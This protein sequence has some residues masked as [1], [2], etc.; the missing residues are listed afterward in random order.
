MIKNY[1]RI[2]WRYILRNKVNS[3]INITGLAIGLVC[4]VLLYFYIQDELSYDR[5]LANA[6]YIY[7]VDLDANMSGEEFRTSNTPPSVGKALLNSF[8]EIESFTRIFHPHDIVVRSEVNG[9]ESFFTERKVLGVDSNFLEIFDYKILKGNAEAA[10]LQPNDIVITESIAK[11][12]FGTE[13]PM[14]KV[15]K[16][17][18]DRKPF[19][20]RAVLQDIPSQSTLDFDILRPI[21]SFPVVKRFTWSWVWLQVETYV[22]LRDHVARNEVSIR[23]LEAKFPDMVQKQ[24]ASAFERIGQPLD[25]L[26]KKGGKWDFK[27]KPL[28]AVHLF[29]AGIGGRHTTLGDIKYVQIFT[30][31]AVFIIIIACVNFV[32]LSTAQSGKRAR[33]VGIRKVLGSQ[34]NQLIRQF[35]IEALVY[36]MVAAFIALI[37]IVILLQPFN[38]ISGKK[39]SFHF[40]YSGYFWLGFATLTMVTGLIAGLYPAFYLTSFKPVAVLKGKLSR[41]SIGNLFLRNGLVIFQFTVSIAM[42][43]CTIITFQQLQYIRNRNLG[44]NKD[45]LLVIANTRRLGEGEETFRQEILKQK[46]IINAS[47]STSIPTKDN[48]G[49]TY[50]PEPTESDKPVAKE[51]GLSSFIVDNDFLSTYKM[52]MLSGRNFSKQFSDSASVILNETAAK[53][54]GW[55]EA[56]GKDIEYPGNNQQLFKVIGVIRDFNVSS[57]HELVGPFALFHKDSKTYDVGSSNITVGFDAGITPADVKELETLW[58]SYV[59]NTPFDYSYLDIDFETLYEADKRLGTV[60]SIFTFISVFVGC[61]GL[62]GLATYTAERRTKEIG[63]RK[64]LGASVQGLVALVSKDFIRLVF[65]AVLIACP[66]AGYFMNTWLQDFAYRISIDVWVFVLAALLA[67]IIAFL[68]ISSQAIRAALTNPVKSIHTE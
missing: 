54:I 61:L 66:I 38:N 27:L 58:K 30:F 21:A 49:D 63:I 13:N 37:L 3:V 31:I 9:R 18:N 10:L 2:A 43:I 1:L 42:I 33:E 41:S 19:V 16:L 45:N 24:A 23:Q 44:L 34:K 35:L 62:F 6:D 26:K 7:Q 48:F 68:T 32:N 8:P 67:L 56:I 57:L 60:F 25:Q 65:I 29:S 5:F 14:G 47:I 51:I 53:Q 20:V 4:I 28:T 36:S 50:V 40:L 17:D 22:K 12:Y 52:E 11:K 46:G 39:I 59:P 15:M 64:V 55:K